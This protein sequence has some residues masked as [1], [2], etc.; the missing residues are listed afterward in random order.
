[1]SGIDSK[2]HILTHKHCSPKLQFMNTM[3]S[4]ELVII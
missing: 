3:M 1:M 2:E 4:L